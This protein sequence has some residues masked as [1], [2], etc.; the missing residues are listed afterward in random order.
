ML[1]TLRVTSP[2]KEAGIFRP[3]HRWDFSGGIRIAGLG[4]SEGVPPRDVDR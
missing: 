3:P 4:P 1:Y 2:L